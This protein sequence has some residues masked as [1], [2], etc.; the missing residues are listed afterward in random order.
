MGQL[1]E[2]LAVRVDGPRAAATA[3]VIEWNFTDVKTTIRTA[4]SNGALIQTENPRTH[5]RADLTVTLT[6]QQL[7]GLLDGGSLDEIEHAGDA[8]A[9]RAL[10]DLL[11]TPDP[12]F[13]I[14]TPRP[15]ESAGTSRS[16]EP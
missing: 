12:A 3:L 15:A 2:S 6:R 13:P 5:A 10:L 7:L 9:L 14:V 4:L 8:T 11:D 16:A 1:F